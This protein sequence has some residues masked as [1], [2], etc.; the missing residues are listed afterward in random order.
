METLTIVLL[1]A[2]GIFAVGNVLLFLLERKQK[3]RE[4]QRLPFGSAKEEILNSKV[5]VLN[6]RVAHLEEKER[7]KQEKPSII[8]AIIKKKPKS[9]FPITKYKKKKKK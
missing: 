7:Q 3:Q 4:A 8:T 1:V 6:K 9:K 5:D 2:I